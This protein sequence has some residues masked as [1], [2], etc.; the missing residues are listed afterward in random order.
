[1]W[2]LYYK[3][4]YDNKIKVFFVQLKFRDLCWT[5]CPSSHLYPQSS[6]S[7]HYFVF[8]SIIHTKLLLAM[9]VIASLFFPAHC[10]DITVIN[11]IPFLSFQGPRAKILGFSFCY[12]KH[13]YKN[14]F[15]VVEIIGGSGKCCK[16]V[17]IHFSAFIDHWV[18]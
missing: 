4:I 15:P 16:F 2:L 6:C 12:V 7:L 1:M 13:C 3:V 10:C 18:L 11:T 9:A 5:S 8:Q 17:Y 14:N